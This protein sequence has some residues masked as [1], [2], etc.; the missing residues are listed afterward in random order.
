MRWQPEKSSLCVLLVSPPQT[1]FSGL[2]KDSHKNS[3]GFSFLTLDGPEMAVK[4]AFSP[5][6]QIG[7]TCFL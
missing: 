2:Y 3:I 6:E 7:E 4:T 1:V 5:N